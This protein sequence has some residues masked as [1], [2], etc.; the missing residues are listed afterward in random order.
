MVALGEKAVAHAFDMFFRRE[1]FI[2]AADQ[3]LARLFRHF[4][5]A[6]AGEKTDMGNEFGPV[7]RRRPCETIAESMTDQHDRRLR[8]SLD[9]GGDIFREIVQRELFHRP[10]AAADAPRLRQRH[11]VAR[12]GERARHFI[13]VA[14]RPAQRGNHDDLPSVFRTHHAALQRDGAAFTIR[15]RDAVAL[16]IHSPLPGVSWTV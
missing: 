15:P 11:A 8:D 3:R 4:D 2:E 9:H 10:F 6:A 5:E 16:E 7:R 1:A 12:L 13:E 14:S